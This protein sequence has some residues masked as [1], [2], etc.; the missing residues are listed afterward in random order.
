MTLVFPKLIKIQGLLIPDLTE[1]DTIKAD[2]ARRVLVIEKEARIRA[3]LSITVTDENRL[4]S[5]LF[6]RRTPG[7]N[8]ASKGSL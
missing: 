3:S 5:I 1:S 6:L 2:Q 7:L 4:S 8:Y